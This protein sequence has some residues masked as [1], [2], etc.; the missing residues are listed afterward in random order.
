LSARKPPFA[1]S[2][3]NLRQ[4]I[5]DAV[6]DFTQEVQQQKFPQS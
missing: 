5:A 1:K 2:Y 3:V 4:I 6:E